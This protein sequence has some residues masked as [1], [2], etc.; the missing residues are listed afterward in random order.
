[1]K[2]L[3]FDLE[4]YK[5]DIFDIVSNYIN[6][7]HIFKTNNKKEFFQELKYN[8]YNLLIIDVNTTLGDQIFQEATEINEKFNILVI[9]TKLTYNSSLSCDGCSL[10]YNRKLLLKP[11]KAK[12]LVNYIQN[13]DKL[14]CKYSTAANNILEILEEVTTQFVSYSYQKEESKII[15]SSGYSNMK[16]LISIID[17]LK[18]HKIKYEVDNDDIKL[19]I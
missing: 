5:D 9:S 17:L 15:L 18:L 14:S 6:D 10:K 4:I 2:V 19:C 3:V 8:Q 1:M 13:Y 7:I 16:E 11:L 12:D